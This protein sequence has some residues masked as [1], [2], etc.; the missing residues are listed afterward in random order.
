MSQSQYD[1]VL[2]VFT[3]LICAPIFLIWFT[4]EAK[5]FVR[6]VASFWGDI[7][8]RLGKR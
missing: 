7:F 6:D 1:A 5:E 2:T 4:P 8:R 3:V